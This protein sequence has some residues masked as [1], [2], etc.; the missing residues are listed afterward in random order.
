MNI[1]FVSL[2]C[3]KNRIDS[4][5]MLALLS[6]R[7]HTIVA[8]P[9]EADAAIVN[10]CAFIDAA[11]SE[12]ID[13]ILELAAYKE[14]R[15]RRL[16]VTGCLAQRYEQDILAELPEIDAV[17]GTA[18]FPAILE[19][20]ESEE[21]PYIRFEDK[22]APLP[23]LD[24][25]VTTGPGWAYIKIADG[26]DNH[27]AYCVIPSIRG[28]FR[29]RPLDA[30][31]AEA[32]KLASDGVREL[33]LVAQD[34]SR[35]GRD[36]RDRTTLCTLL[37][38]LVKIPG[39][40]WIRLHY[41][42]PQ[43]LTDEL[44]SLIA[45]EP[46]LLPYFDVPIQH[47]SNSVLRAMRRPETKESIETLFGKI[48]AAIPAAVIRTSLIV[49]FPGEGE[50]EFEELMD[51]LR[52]Q[53]LQR[54]GAFVFSPQEGTPAASL[55]G[56]CD[57]ETALLRQE[58]VMALQAEIMDEYNASRIGSV[59]PVLCEGRENDHWLGRSMA[60]AP[61]VDEQI[62]FTGPAEPGQIVNVRLLQADAGELRGE[63]V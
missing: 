45:D 2:G 11:Q 3:A 46:K 56:A 6:A 34:V 24:R 33:V 43:L 8:E 38:E 49:G 53:K 50:S 19:A 17:L 42:Y 27:C 59:F 57:E 13:T 52:R 22:N 60:D 55:P 16:I 54:A 14:D 35:Y 61:D 4:E 26:C 30:I 31:L 37:R 10:T 39:L 23:E 36:F 47:A 25:L 18:S 62:A 63:V 12:A 40:S 20:L 21:T 48:R 58:R 29:S 44:I 15:L 28:R 5:Q 9:A 41:L 7:G 1:Y 51:F 32:E